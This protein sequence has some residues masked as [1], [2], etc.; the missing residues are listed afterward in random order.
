MKLY[1]VINLAAAPTLSYFLMV[2]LMHRGFFSIIFSHGKSDAQGVLIAFREAI[3]YK[4]VSKHIDND[5]RYIILNVLIDNNPV[6]LVNYYASND[7]AE[8]VK[9]LEELN[10][11]SDALDSH[12]DTKYIW[13]GDFNMILNTYLDADGGSPALKI[14][15]VAKL[16]SMMSDNN[17]CDIFHIRNPETRRYIWRRKTRFK[18]RRL[19]FFSSFRQ[20]SRERTFS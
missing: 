4:I 17:L 11:I 9:I 13:G 12:E 7:E 2:N 10:R 5:G 3:K 8:Q 1:G 16:L 6:V 15:S 18:Q 20:Y 19:D 14:K